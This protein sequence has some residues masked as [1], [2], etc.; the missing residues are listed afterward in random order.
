MKKIALIL[1]SIAVLG[2]LLS[3]YIDKPSSRKDIVSTEMIRVNSVADLQG[4]PATTADILL[5][6]DFAVTV[7]NGTLTFPTNPINGQI[8]SVTTRSQITNV[9]LDGGGIPI[10]GTIGTLA[11]G[12]VVAWVYNQEGNRWFRNP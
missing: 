1:L 12:G 6:I 4:I 3:S 10:S 8:I 2:A 5:C 9:T 7:T 11:A